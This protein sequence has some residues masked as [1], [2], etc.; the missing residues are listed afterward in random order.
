MTIKP[1]GM[2][3]QEELVEM[4]LGLA[5]IIAC[6]YANIPQSSLDE[7]TAEANKALSDAARHFDPAKGEF[8][9]YAGRAIRNALNSL[10]EKQL[11]YVRLHEFS[12]D[13]PEHGASATTE[14]PRIQN[15]PDIAGH[16]SLEIRANESRRVLEDV[17]AELPNRSR[18]VL[19]WLR[20]G[21]SYSEIGEEMGISKQGAHKIGQDALLSLKEKLMARG[22]SGLDSKGFLKSK[23]EHRPPPS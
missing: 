10:Y 23:S 15:V 18:K 12:L 9:S 21:K 17:L 11:R 2:N 19:Q 8:T 1:I 4:H 3:A 16:A 5:Q 6:E 7:I 22:F 20:E 14:S 13:V